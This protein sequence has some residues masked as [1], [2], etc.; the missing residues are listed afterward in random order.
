[1]SA[2]KKKEQITAEGAIVVREK[3]ESAKGRVERL[4]NRFY[5]LKLDLLET[6]VRLAH[7]QMIHA[8]LH[9]RL[10]ATR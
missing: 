3:R 9:A 6:K 1:M 8:E 10:P 7:E 5:K 4:A 2:G